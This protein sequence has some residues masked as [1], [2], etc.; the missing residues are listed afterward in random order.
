MLS[1]GSN[2]LIVNQSRRDIVRASR[3][4]ELITRTPQSARLSLANYIGDQLG[5]LPGTDAELCHLA[6]ALRRSR[7]PHA[8]CRQAVDLLTYISSF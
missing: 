5:S 3:K 2:K 6:H 8:S 7:L 1:V 4:C